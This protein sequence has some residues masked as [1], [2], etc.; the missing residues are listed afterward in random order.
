[1]FKIN[2]YPWAKHWSTW[3]LIQ[4]TTW[5]NT[6]KSHIATNGPFSSGTDYNESVNQVSCAAVPYMNLL[7]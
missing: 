7:Q 1:M 6:S 2:A 4:C 3:L 5:I